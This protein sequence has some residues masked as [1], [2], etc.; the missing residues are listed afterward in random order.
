MKDRKLTFLHNYKVIERA[1]NLWVEKST[2]L[3]VYGEVSRI[4]D[5]H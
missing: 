4:I 2:K 5:Y 3:K 1:L